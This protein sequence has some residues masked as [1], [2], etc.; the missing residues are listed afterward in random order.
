M[1]DWKW[2]SVNGWPERIIAAK[3]HSINSA[4]SSAW[5]HNKVAKGR[6]LVEIA[7]V[8]VVRAGNVHVVEAGNLYTRV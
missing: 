2:A 6:T 5:C 7:L 3:S 8:E 1:N 4:A